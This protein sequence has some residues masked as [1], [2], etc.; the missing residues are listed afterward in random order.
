MKLK[1]AGLRKLRIWLNLNGKELNC[2]EYSFS[3]SPPGS[4]K[5]KRIS[6][7]EWDM[8]SEILCIHK[9]KVPFFT[10]SVAL[11]LIP[12][13]AWSVERTQVS[14]RQ[15]RLQISSLLQVTLIHFCD[16]QHQLTDISCFLFFFLQQYNGV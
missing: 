8:D 3:F 16:L 15:T 2:H 10:L 11:S 4:A 1:S 12:E 13:A 7:P 9:L 5:C 14:Y 6:Y